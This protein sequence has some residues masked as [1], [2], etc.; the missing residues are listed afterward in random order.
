MTAVL[1]ILAF[2][3]SKRERENTPFLQMKESRE[4]DMIMTKSKNDRGISM[5]EK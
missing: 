2:N 4:Y 1:L 5:C 3:G